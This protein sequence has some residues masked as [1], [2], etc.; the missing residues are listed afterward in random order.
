MGS[1]VLLITQEEAS[2]RDHKMIG[3]GSPRQNLVESLLILPTPAHRTAPRPRE[4][5]IEA[6]GD[7]PR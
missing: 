7:L 1:A 5:T 3:T 4:T 6:T 2:N